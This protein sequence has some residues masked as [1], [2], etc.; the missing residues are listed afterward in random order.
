MNDLLHSFPGQEED[1]PVFVFIRQYPVAFIP[2][3]A[4]FLIV[5]AFSLLAQFALVSNVIP[6][7]SVDSVNFG[8]LFFGLFQLFVLVVF[9]VTVLDF[10]YDIVIVTDRR[11]VDINQNMLFFRQ[12]SELLMEDVEDVNSIIQGFL[13]T[14][15]NYGHVQIQ[16]AGTKENFI[17]DNILHPR[18]VAAIVINLSEQAKRGIPENARVPETDILGVIDNHLLRDTQELQDMGAILPSDLRRI[19]RD[20]PTPR[21]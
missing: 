7:L 15:F 3:A 11:L 19:R 1:E 16:T 8:I 18:E 12:I 2:T 21:P 14:V 13:P 10:Y 6:E 9:L 17:I 4:V 5:F 20:P